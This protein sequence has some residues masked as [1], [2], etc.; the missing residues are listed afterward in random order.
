LASVTGFS[1]LA[2]AAP[3]ASPIQRLIRV[4]E[5]R[6]YDL[7]MKVKFLRV[8]KDK[9]CPLDDECKKPGDATVV[10]RIKVGK[11]RGNIYQLHTN[12]GRQ[13]LWIPL[14][15]K[16]KKGKR[17]YRI[18]V[19]SLSPLPFPGKVTPPENFRLDLNVD[20]KH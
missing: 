19:N 14:D 12:T 5:T 1:P 2:A 7:G 4:G 6:N 11:K 17:Y 18:M 16:N 20:L 3:E 15:Q 8:I 13:K 9:R 10:L